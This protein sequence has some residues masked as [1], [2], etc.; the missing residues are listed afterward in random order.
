M[1][2]ALLA[3]ATA[4]IVSTAQPASADDIRCNASAQAMPIETAIGKAEQ[5]GY[6]VSEAKRSKGCWKIEGYDRNGAE[7]ELI[8]DPQSGDVMKPSR[9]RPPAVN[10]G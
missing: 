8:L 9:W 10:P 5:L 6:A 4:T 3:L 2:Y 7:I 1:K